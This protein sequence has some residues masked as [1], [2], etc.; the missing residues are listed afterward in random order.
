M[1]SGKVRHDVSCC[2]IGCRLRLDGQS[3]AAVS[4]DDEERIIESSQTG[5]CSAT[6]RNADD[7]EEL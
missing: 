6:V 3:S 5:I 2:W 4:D 7:S 1:K